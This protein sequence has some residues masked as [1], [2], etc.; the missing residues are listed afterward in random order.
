MVQARPR[1]RLV[2]N[3]P[4]VTFLPNAWRA[5]LLA[6]AGT[7]TLFIAAG[8]IQN[9][10][11]SW[12]FSLPAPT[13]SAG[14]P[15]SAGAAER[16]PIEV[17][18]E[19]LHRLGVRVESVRRGPLTSTVTAVATI[20][21]DESRLSHVHA[22]V[23]G[24]VEQL[25]VNTT[26]QTVG[27][28]A[29]LARIFSRELLSSQTEYLAARRFASSGFATAVV[30]SGRT[31]LRVLGMSA[32]EITAI[33]RT[34][35]PISLVTVVAPRSGTVVHRGISV[36]T[37]VDPSTEL[38]TLADLSQV[39]VLAEIPERDIPLVRPG[40]SAM[41]H[42]PASGRE[43]FRGRIDF[44]YPTLTERTR[45]LRVRMSI[46]NPGGSL[47]P[48]LYGTAAFDAVAG[49]AITVPR[50]AVIDTGRRQHVFVVEGNLFVPR[51]VTVGARM[52]DRVEIRAGLREGERIVSS[53]T[54]L[55]DSESR[56]RATGGA[57]AHRHGG[58]PDD[59]PPSSP[60]GRGAVAPN[61]DP[62]ANH[63]SR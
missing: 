63:P 24:W 55:L 52:R 40:M 42:F 49:E 2:R 12:P 16:V 1:R 7:A 34:G 32:G 6:A 46:P 38:L 15:S 14:R 58:T 20:A 50:D 23:A 5:P 54:F 22:R 27:A 37:A 10:R 18:P 51:L 13:N 53:G 17:R 39:W 28:G 44:I 19:E 60:A 3:S 62:H 30:P 41:L 26:G 29:P 47:R 43:P 33:E 48:G 35:R 8:V 25:Y 9:Q 56:L 11:Q 57:G 4:A 31:R 45:T 36:G 21:I 61:A 59:A